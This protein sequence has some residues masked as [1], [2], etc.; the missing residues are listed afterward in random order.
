MEFDNELASFFEHEPEMVLANPQQFR[1]K[2]GI[3]LDT[4]K[5]SFVKG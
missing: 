4:F 2:L 5:A 1:H 3:G